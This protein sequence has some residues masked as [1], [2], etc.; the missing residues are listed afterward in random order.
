MGQVLSQP[1]TTKESG[2]SSHPSRGLEW[3]Y[4]AMQ[5]WRNAMEDAHFAVDL[6]NWD[7]ATCFAIFDGHGGEQV[8]RFCE[9]YLP[10]EINKRSHK[11]VSASLT[12]AFHSMDDMLREPTACE[13]LRSFSSGGITAKGWAGN[14]DCIG[15]TA[16]VCVVFPDRIVVA[17]CGDSRSVL[18]RRGTALPLSEDH[19]PNL[20]SE[21]A[22]ISKAGGS[23]E[24]QQV[25]NIVQH[26]VNGNLNLS[27]S[28]GDLEYKKNYDML[29]SEQMIC[30][31]PDV[32]IFKREVSD[33][34]IVLAC[35]GIWDVMSSQDAVDFVR[36][37]LRAPRRR[38]ISHIAEELL[39][40]CMSPDLTMTHGLGGDN[41]TVIIVVL[42]TPGD[43]ETNMAENA[44]AKAGGITPVVV[45]T[46]P[47]TTVEDSDIVPHGLCSCRLK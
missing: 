21:R 32:S 15:C 1:V 5:G 3:G 45:Q 44:T 22:R 27:R 23:V 34:F 4:S 16:N 35:D 37:R 2:D 18:S 12:E 29:P 25:G 17:N 14:P 31:T 42:G 6:E 20:P 38:P 24:R 30:S 41:M 26:R 8:A 9:R 39:D 11:D 47:F 13:V 33:E 7:L 28:I 19:K 10:D 40:Q 36:E 43:D 46:D